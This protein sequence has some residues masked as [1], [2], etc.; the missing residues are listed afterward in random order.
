MRPQFADVLPALLRAADELARH[1][2]RFETFAKVG[3]TVVR[4]T[5]H[6]GNQERQHLLEVGVGCRVVVAGKVGFGA[7]AGS[8][9]AAGR[10]AARLA[11]ENL[12]PGPDPLPPARLLG[13]TAVPRLP[14][15][16][17][18][19]AR[20]GFLKALEKG[21]A[22]EGRGLLLREVRMLDGC[23]TASILTGEGF[24]AR[25]PACGC[26]I[27]V[28]IAAGEG[29]QRL[30][31]RAARS[32]ADLDPDAFVRQACET[33]R[34]TSRG[35]AASGG[36]TDVL[37]APAVAAPLVEALGAAIIEDTLHTGAREPRIAKAWCL[38][39][40]RSGPSGLLPLPFDGEGVASRPLTLLADGR[41]QERCGCWADT[42]QR[43]M[44]AGGAV[45][46]TYVAPPK[47]GPANVVLH[48]I[49]ARSP[50]E[51]LQMM[52]QGCY[53]AI[54]AGRLHRE[55]ES[56]RFSLRAGAVSV[57]H[58]RF[59]AAHPIVELRGSLRRLLAGLVAAGNDPASFSLSCAVTVPTLLLR[60]LEVA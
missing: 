41:L 39:D 1:R 4:R 59:A 48:A 42:H 36:L 25:A 33:S 35:S 50:A 31:H 9:A 30:F 52:E 16:G 5:G 46:S 32:L 17:G 55:P 40:E 10:E 23:S 57:R 56:G 20:E 47:S 60:G 8:H 53:L 12:L 43:G 34:L 11:R 44:G 3:E 49:P 6:S 37:L 27:E 24:T 29:P 28:L 45:R 38:V 54:P 19:E 13:A 26:A 22:R 7:A 58:G 14:E 18:E 2:C 21:F 51:L 15:A